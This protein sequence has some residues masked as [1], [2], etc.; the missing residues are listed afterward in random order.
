MSKKA[1]TIYSLIEIAENNLKN[2]RVLLNQIIEDGNSQVKLSTGVHLNPYTKISREEEVSKDVV[3]G[4]FDGEN[5]VGDNGRTYIVPQ[6]YASK[7]QLVVGDRMKWILTDSREVFK[8]IQPVE[9]QKVEGKFTTD[10]DNY[11]VHISG[12]DYPVKI[13]K[14]SCT[15]AMKT[16]GL[17]NGDWISVL[18]PRD[19]K[20]HWGAFL[21][22]VKSRDDEKH[23]SPSYKKYDDRVEEKKEEES[24]NDDEDEDDKESHE[25]QSFA[26]LEF[27]KQSLNPEF[28]VNKNYAVK[29]EVSSSIGKIY[30]DDEEDDDDDEI[31]TDDIDN[32]Y[33]DLSTAIP[34]KAKP[35][36]TR[37]IKRKVPTKTVSKAAKVS[38]AKKPTV[39]PKSPAARKTA[40]RKT[41]KIENDY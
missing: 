22:I 26:E 24:N 15:F 29:K 31:D 4:Y 33:A 12:Y 21:S 7:T 28:L 27:F 41:T 14:A 13:L 2:A 38:T 36:P 11:Y 9:R 10:G 25:A 40:T 17:Q 6:N 32:D 19:T 3:E 34:V 35:R 39:K 20:A 30:M 16:Q 23:I 5:M 8:L 37:V 18:I 1:E